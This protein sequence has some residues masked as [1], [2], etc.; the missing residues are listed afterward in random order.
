MAGSSGFQLGGKG[1]G[2]QIVGGKPYSQYTPE[3]YAAQ[4][5]DEVSRAGTAGTAIGTGA[6]NALDAL[7]TVTGSTPSTPG[8]GTPGGVPPRI[9]GPGGGLPGYGTFD[10]SDPGGGSGGPAGTYDTGTPQGGGG[11]RPHISQPN[12]NASE[13]ATFGK[14]KDQVG[15]ETSG[16]LTGLR[17][18]LASRGMLGGQGEYRGTTGVATQGQAQ[19][20][21][22]SRQQAVTHLSNEMDINKANLGADVAT[23]GQDISSATTRRGQNMDYTLGGRGQDI[24]QRGQDIQW[25]ESQA[26]LA[27]TKSLQEAAQRQ[28]ILQGISGAINGQTLY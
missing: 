25:N 2:T 1:G 13:A 8:T 27:L 20:G 23:R 26:Q 12:Q 3:W 5:A 17:S 9:G 28:Q 24:T 4:K 14:A 6:K 10:A 11:G 18:A 15:Q 22:V 21:D 16:A 7:G 19:M